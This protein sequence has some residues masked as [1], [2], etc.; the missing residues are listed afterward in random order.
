[1]LDWRIAVRTIG[2]QIGQCVGNP[3]QTA[4]LVHRCCHDSPGESSRTSPR[5]L[6]NASVPNSDQT[7]S[8]AIDR[9]SRVTASR[10]LGA[11]GPGLLAHWWIDSSTDHLASRPSAAERSS[12]GRSRR[13]WSGPS[14]RSSPATLD[15]LQASR[16]N[17]LQHFR[18]AA[19]C[20]TPT[21]STKVSTSRDRT[22]QQRE[23]EGATADRRRHHPTRQPRRRIADQRVRALLDTCQQSN[24]SGSSEIES[25]LP[26]FR[27]MSAQA[28]PGRR[29]EVIAAFPPDCPGYK[30]KPTCFQAVLACGHTLDRG[31][32]DSSIPI[33]CNVPDRGDDHRLKSCLPPSRAAEAGWAGFD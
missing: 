5:S 19:D 18:V 17:D 10:G 28:S 4:P 13:A 12:A 7:P 30:S 6:E 2:A 29:T 23:P 22:T 3:C 14:H 21:K 24:R 27:N 9:H 11:T 8:I 1:M 20:D 33:P 15:G 26:Q 31:T 32:V 25:S 16:E